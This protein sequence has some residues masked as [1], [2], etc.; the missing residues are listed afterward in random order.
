MLSHRNS[1]SAGSVSAAYG[2]RPG[3][4]VQQTR[5]SNAPVREGHSAE[6]EVLTQPSTIQVNQPHVGTMANIRT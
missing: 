4:T 2:F 3:G 5:S 6:Y 1:Y